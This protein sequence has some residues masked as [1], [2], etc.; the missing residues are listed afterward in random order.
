MKKLIVILLFPMSAF[1]QDDLKIKIC[2]NLN[3]FGRLGN[4]IIPLICSN[5]AKSGFS[6]NINVRE[7]EGYLSYYGLCVQRRGIGEYMDSS[8]LVFTYESGKTFTITSFTEKNELE[9]SYF[10]K[11]SQYYHDFV[12]EKI[13]SIKFINLTTG[14]NM[15]YQIKPTQKTF[16]QDALKEIMKN[17]FVSGY[18]N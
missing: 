17:K 8:R 15:I 5:D 9:W 11:N 18:C 16:F 4:Y 14:D 1:A 7:I 2:K 12:K 3:Y 13:T 6:I 10:D